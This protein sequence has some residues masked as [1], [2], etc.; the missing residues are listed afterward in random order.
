LAD[1]DPN[2]VGYMGPGC[3]GRRHDSRLSDKSKAK[4]QFRPSSVTQITAR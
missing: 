3:A 4:T 2:H 1:R